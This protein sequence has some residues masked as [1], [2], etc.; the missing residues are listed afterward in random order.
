MPSIWAIGDVTNRIQL[1]PVALM[2][3]TCLAVSFTQASYS[4]FI[5]SVVI[6]IVLLERNSSGYSGLLAGLVGPAVLPKSHFGGFCRKPYFS[7][8][9]VSQ[10]TRMYHVLFLRKLP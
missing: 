2:E 1:T 7:T 8:N 10:I 5:G 4:V 3:G 6:D 9:P